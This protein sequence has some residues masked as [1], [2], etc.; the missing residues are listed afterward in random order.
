M[1]TQIAIKQSQQQNWAILFKECKESGLVYCKKVLAKNKN[2]PD[3]N[4]SS[5]ENK[6]E[7]STAKSS[8]GGKK[9]RKP[10][11][12]EKGKACRRFLQ[13]SRQN[14]VCFL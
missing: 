8:T 5:N 11:G 4:P 9:E 1:N 14:R 12:K 2:I 7:R 6:A 10:S 3:A 13:A